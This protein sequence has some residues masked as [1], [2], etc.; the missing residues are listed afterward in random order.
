ML[1]VPEFALGRREQL[2][3]DLHVRIHRA[4]NVEE[5]QNLHAVAPL[6][7]SER[8]NRHAVRRWCRRDRFVG[9][10]FAR[11]AAHRRSAT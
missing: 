1:E 2:L 4:A 6:G 10:A 8:A 5:Q 9:H 3:A 11:E 7:A